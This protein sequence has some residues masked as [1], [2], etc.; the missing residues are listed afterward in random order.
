MGDQVEK[1]FT[2]CS[3]FILSRPAKPEKFKGPNKQNPVDKP[4]NIALNMT[5][6][7]VSELPE[8]IFVDHRPEIV[9]L[10]AEILLNYNIVFYRAF[11][12]VDMD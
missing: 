12:H 5:Q 4:I 2:N 7:D 8:S 11:K 9:A 6:F 10:R 3:S 1:R